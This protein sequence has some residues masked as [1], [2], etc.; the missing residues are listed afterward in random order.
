[1]FVFFHNMLAVF[2]R[3]LGHMVHH[4]MYRMLT[5]VLPVISFAF[6][7]V[8]FDNGAINKLPVAILDEDHTPLSRKLSM[9]IGEAPGVL[10]A[11]DIGDMAE[12]ERLMHEGKISGIVQI[13]DNFES[14]IY[15]NEQTHV[16]AYISG[17]NISVNGMLSKD[18]QTT[19]QTF[20][21][22]IQ[23]TKLQAA[24]LT[25][26]QAMAQVMPIRFSKHVISNPYLN[27]GY[28]LA[29]IFMLM[30]LMIFTVLTTIYAIGRE[31]RYSTAGEWIATGGGSITA[32]LLGKTL[33]I[34]FIMTILAQVMFVIM[35]RSV[36]APLNGSYWVLLAGVELFIISY[37]AIAVFIITVLGNLRLGLSIGGGYSVLAFTF[38]GLTFPIMAMYPIMQAASKIFPF[39]Y[40]T[41]I[42]ID[43]AMRGAPS[44]YSIKPLICMAVF[45]VLPMMV[46]PRLRKIATDSKYW[47]KL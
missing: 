22:G 16:D 41:E 6:F 44:V 5:I 47:G 29:P 23:L 46:M 10:R 32:S 27:Y 9:M 37:Q 26:Y 7:A 28:Y 4:R 12:G 45:I 36:G 43:Q 30:M 31:L 33:P 21:A 3:E 18:I 42:F 14:D 38:S 19:V 2:R 11:Y 17:T 8:L 40:F 13:P 25:A 39:T 35:F 24:G 20:A 34:T 1:M 15:G